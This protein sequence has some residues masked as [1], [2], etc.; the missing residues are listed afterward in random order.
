M[1]N[2]LIRNVEPELKRKIQARAR[3]HQRSLSEEVKTLVKRA[4]AV[5]KPADGLGTRLFSLLEEKYRSDDY[6]FEVR[7]YPKPPDFE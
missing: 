6:V 4:L 7:D 3:A 1:S 5:E 2:L